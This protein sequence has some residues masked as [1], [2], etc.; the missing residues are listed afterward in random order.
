ML[1]RNADIEMALKELREARTVVDILATSQV[2][3]AANELREV[4]LEQPSVTA[5]VL[6][7]QERAEAA[8]IR[9]IRAEF[10]SRD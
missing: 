10:G 6:E 5:E 1:L 7:R 4:M 9:S 3:R 8:F 2:R